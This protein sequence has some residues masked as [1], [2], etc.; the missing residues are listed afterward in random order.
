[1]RNSGWCGSA[2]ARRTRRPSGIVLGAVVSGALAFISPAVPIAAAQPSLPDPGADS[3]GSNELASI[4]AYGQ[5][6]LD[7]LTSGE[8]ARIVEARRDLVETTAPSTRG[9]G[10]AS[11]AF[12]AAIARTLL[13]DAADEFMGV[14]TG[15]DRLAAVNAVLIAGALADRRSVSVIEDGFAEGEPATRLASAS[16]AKLMLTRLTTIETPAAAR[17]AGNVQTAVGRALAE[18]E[19]PLVASAMVQA[20]MSTPNV[21][22]L[23]AGGLRRAAS[24]LAERM[25]VLREVAPLDAAHSG[26]FDAASLLLGDVRRQLVEGGLGTDPDRV[27]LRDAAFVA[28]QV[29]SIAED[30]L[31]AHAEAEMDGEGDE[32]VGAAHAEEMLPLIGVAEQVVQQAER[33]LL[34]GRAIGERG[35]LPAIEDWLEDGAQPRAFEDAG[36]AEAIDVWVGVLTQPPFSFEASAFERRGDAG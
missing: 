13:S 30:A 7:A 21:D 9:V 18:E 12:N 15:D 10:G 6:V 5:W 1:M 22:T 32:G 35:V 16:A 14:I 33:A 2:A 8:P 28:L 24:A 3:Y 25:R 4:A 23:H 20:L 19:S 26:W 29:L 31:L 17:D 11:A 34:G 27:M 36:V